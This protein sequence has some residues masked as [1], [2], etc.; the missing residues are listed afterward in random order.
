[1]F[2]FLKE[3]LKREEKSENAMARMVSTLFSYALLMVIL[4]LIVCLLI[5]SNFIFGW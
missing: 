3:M 4:G 1:M 2:K 5:F